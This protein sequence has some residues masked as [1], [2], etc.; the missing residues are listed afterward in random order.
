MTDY[1]R[2]RACEGPRD[3]CYREHHGAAIVEWTFRVADWWLKR[4]DAR[5]VNRGR[6]AHHEV[7]KGETAAL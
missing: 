3:E 5:I 4:R 2:F 7:T 6:G 1:P